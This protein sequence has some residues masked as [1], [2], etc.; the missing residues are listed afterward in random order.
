MKSGYEDEVGRYLEGKN[1]KMT[2]FPESEILST[3][4]Y[5]FVA[6]EYVE[7]KL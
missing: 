4:L 5:C 1:G 7:L 3:Y 2:I 6:G